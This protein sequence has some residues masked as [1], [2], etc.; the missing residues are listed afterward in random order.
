METDLVFE[1]VATGFCGFEML[2][3]QTLFVTA[4]YDLTGAEWLVAGDYDG[5]FGAFNAF[6]DAAEYARFV[7]EDTVYVFED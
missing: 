3:F 5:D 1:Q 6:C 7:I 4:F 2:D